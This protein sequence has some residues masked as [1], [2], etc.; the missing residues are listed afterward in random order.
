MRMQ[1][2][3]TDAYVE[4]DSDDSDA[5]RSL[6]SDALDEDSDFATSN[7]GKKT[8][9]PL[10]R[11]RGSTGS[12]SKARSSSSPKKTSPRKKRRTDEDGVEGVDEEVDGDQEIVGVIVQAPKIGRGTFLSIFYAFHINIFSYFSPPRS[13]ISEYIQFPETTTKSRM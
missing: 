2:E 12:P 10:K 8:L 13:N 5:L 3:E 6:D 7:R 9:S 1:I 4:D 11:K